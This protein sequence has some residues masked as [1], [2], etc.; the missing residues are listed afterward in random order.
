[1]NNRTLAAITP[2][3]ARL[4]AVLCCILAI[5][6]FTR[7]DVLV[8]SDRP[9]P[10]YTIRLSAPG[11][12]AD[13]MDEQVTRP[14][15]EAVRAL[16][17]ALHIASES[18]AGSA[19]VT[20]QTSERIGSDYKDRL[21]KKLGEAIK[22]L[23][24]EQWS[25]SQD[26]LA[27]SKLGFYLLHGSDIQ[28]LSDVARHTVYEKLIGIPGV[29]RVEVDD[30]SVRQQIDIVFHPSMMTAYGLTPE[31]VL[32]QLQGDVVAEQ[33][34][35]A[36]KQGE[37]SSFQ[38]SSQAEGPQGLGKKLILTDKGYIPLKMIA[39]IQ[40]LRGS[41]GEAVSVY[42]GEPAVG[43]TL[44]AAEAGQVPS[45]R[46]A[47]LQAVSE[48]NASAAGKYRLDL[49]EDSAQPL[50][51]AIG[52]LAWL[53]GITVVLCS[54]FSGI[55]E[56][57]MAPAV[58]SL[59]AAFMAVG[60][61]LGGMW[62]TGVPLTLL[63]LGPVL[64]FT[65]LYAGAGHALFH[66][67]NRLPAYTPASCLTEAWKL[68]KPL[69][70]TVVVLAACWAALIMTDFLTA[71][72]RVFLYDT[73][74]LL[75]FGTLSLIVVYGFIA[76]VLTGAWIA[77]RVLTS[78]RELESKAARIFVKRWERI[79]QQG[80]LPYGIALLSAL[81]VV[82]LLHSFVLVDP[83]AKTETADKGLTLDMVRG[84]SVDQAIRSAQMAEERL[85]KLAEV[86][87]LYTVAT[88]EK[89]SFHLK[90][91]DKYL[92]TR[93]R[94]DM[95]KEI[96]KLLRDIPGTDPFAF[97]VSDDV[98]TRLEFTVKGPSLQTAEE[99]AKG[100][101]AFLEKARG[102]DKEGREII[103]DER[104]GEKVT[105]TNI[106]MRPKPDM[107]ARYRITEAE[108]KRQLQSYL[109]EKTIGSVSL[110]DR[111]VP[112]NVRFPDD[113]MAYPEQ[114][115]N[116]LIRTQK[117][118]VR[119][120]ELVDWTIGEA[121]PVYQRE[122][123]LYVFKVSSAVSEPG[124]I[125]SMSYTIPLNMKKKMTVPEGYIIY[126]ADE[127]KKVTEDEAGTR[128]WSGRLLGI[129]TLA[130]I[131]LLASLLLQRRARDGLFALVLLPVLSG[132]VL[133]GLLV[134]D[135]QLNVMGLYGI[136]AAMALLI[137]QSLLH[138]DELFRA[139]ASEETIWNGVRAGSKR[140]CTQQVSVFGAVAVACVPLAGGWMDGVDFF[141]S[142]ACA[143][144]FGSLLSAF[145][146]VVLLPGM[147]FA[148]E[149]R[150]AAK[151][152]LTIPIVLRRIQI[153]RENQLV[154]RQDARG[155][156]RSLKQRKR[157]QLSDSKAAAQERRRELVQ[158]DFQQLSS[159]SKD[160]H[161]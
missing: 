129:A 29:A 119:L 118:T 141:A 31:D 53:A 56:R 58:L 91:R 138:M 143:L 68:M 30:A 151:A 126:N 159:S 135:R 140:A 88:G 34:G 134:M 121:P 85:R 115:K 48:L 157:E 142:F 37:Q 23:G 50:A 32:G 62:L 14:V 150:Q 12:A 61:M 70:L 110:N 79:V 17:S 84:S 116:A 101:L 158:D 100:V 107:L 55:R 122:D 35:T 113:W 18:R 131:V 9:V 41:K 7:M 64:V 139:R 149:R 72:D 5:G 96:D 27:D 66:R 40:D 81:A 106:D 111:S 109:G 60:S 147:Q 2:A 33:V 97:V 90:L 39:D 74:P 11:M 26:N 8:F 95:E 59:L 51:G 6:A 82:L 98:K 20:V 76:P 108:V 4:M 75:V 43:V 136:A 67:L 152:E 123:G 120:A 155:R 1:M 153:W 125:E 86:S 145:A 128:D 52:Q 16:G 117:G 87:D 15:E 21:E 161:L 104:I 99:I 77:P 156:K 36:G 83:Y 63:T 105:G 132:G 112:V 93:S 57:R 13:K 80:F 146:T 78:G 160:A 47:T 124:R 89:L 148:A 73:W 144:L 44:Y 94:T 28:T 133:L 22:P 46:K 19:T 3:L 127:L 137:Q 54:V 103:T 38:W 102:R 45:I 24:V 42:R 154:R 69:L 25:I 49:F 114:V 65:L 10:E 92:W 71:E 130:A